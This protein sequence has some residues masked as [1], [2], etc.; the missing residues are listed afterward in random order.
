MGKKTFWF[1][2]IF[3]LGQTRQE[4]SRC[5]MNMHSLNSCD[6]QPLQLLLLSDCFYEHFLT[7]QYQL[8][9]VPGMPTQVSRLDEL[10]RKYL[11]EQLYSDLKECLILSRE[12]EQ[13]RVTLV[14]GIFLAIYL[15]PGEC[16]CSQPL[17]N[18]HWAKLCNS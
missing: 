6:K 14:V 10:G 7:C 18:T 16:S 3:V 9:Q 11:Y 15:G 13:L 2:L 8:D 12:N 1:W 17:K 4:Y 5:R